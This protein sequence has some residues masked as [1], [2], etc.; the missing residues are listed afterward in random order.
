[1]NLW[2]EKS[3]TLANET[4]YLDRLHDIYPMAVN[5]SRD[6]KAEARERITQCF[7][8]RDSINLIKV[9]LSQE[10]FPIKDSYVAYLKRDKDAIIRNT[11]TVNRL[12]TMLYDMGLDEI[13]ARISASKETNRQIGSLFKKWIESGALDC[14]LTDSEDDLLTRPYNMVFSGS[15]SLMKH[16]AHMNF[17]YNRNK[18]LDFMG[19]FNGVYVLGEAKFLTDFG[20]HQNA[21]FSDAI[22]TM[23]DPLEPSGYPVK[24]IAILDGVLY[25]NKGN[26]KMHHSITQE[27]SNDDVILSALLLKDYLYSL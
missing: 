18:G 23:K 14:T 24:T 6:I 26:N 4:N 17:G 13:F 5:P 11:E 7:A 1:M 19:K 12:A 9:L 21:Q 22:N 3:I 16:I 10:I 27:F 2:T 20:G 8:E 25:I 15:D